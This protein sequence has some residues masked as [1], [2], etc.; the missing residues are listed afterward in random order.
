MVC[1]N[2]AIAR[3]V[4]PTK[5][6]EDACPD[7]PQSKRKPRPVSLGSAERP[8]FG[9]NPGDTNDYISEGEKDTND[10]RKK[11]GTSPNSKLLKNVKVLIAF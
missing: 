1:M 9:A 2:N 3:G 7:L 4:P 6:D 5:F 8:F 10:L 11:Q